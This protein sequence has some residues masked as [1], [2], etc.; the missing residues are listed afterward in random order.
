MRDNTND[1]N[2]KEYLSSVKNALRILNSFSEEE[3]EKKV[4][5]LAV[6]LGLAKSTVSRLMLTLASEG[7]VIKDPETLRYRLGLSVLNLSGIITSRMEIHREA[8][9]CLQNL[10]KTIDETAHLVILEGVEVIY[11]AK[12]ECT[13]PVR[14]S[15]HI[16][17]KNPAH[18]TSS[19]KVLLAHQ[20]QEF[21]DKFIEHGLQKYTAHT[22]TDPDAFLRHL[23]TI[24]EQGY[25]TS[26][27]EFIDGVV[28][29]GAPVRD[30][31]GKV[32]AAITIVGPIQRIHYH[33][34]DFFIKKAIEVGK[35]IS[36]KMG[37]AAKI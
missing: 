16:G 21:I 19:G 17:K 31:T 2:N 32:V 8:L 37:Y 4:S 13:H 26:F 7:F 24:K 12:M 5:D 6:K 28:T 25:S 22:I 23:N 18:C 30:Y 9:P 35:D 27:E 14:I 15:S 34:I 36:E 20:N 3:P 10:V 11:L 33:N 1:T 29:I